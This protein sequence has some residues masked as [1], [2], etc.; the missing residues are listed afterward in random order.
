MYPTFVF[1]ITQSKPTQHT[2]QLLETFVE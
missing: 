1:M 2:K